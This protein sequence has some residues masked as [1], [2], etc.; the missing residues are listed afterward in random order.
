MTQTTI[1]LQLHRWAQ[2]DQSEI[3]CPVFM[4]D[5]S[6]LPEKLD[7]ISVVLAT[8]DETRAGELIARGAERVLLGD[9]VL[10]D[11]DVYRRLALLHGPER[12][13]VWVP[14][15]RMSVSWQLDFHSNEDFRCVTPSLAKPT[16]E[17]IDG[18]GQGTGTDAV[19]WLDQMLSQ[20]VAMALLAVDHSD[21]HDLNLCAELV[22][23][24]A[25]QVYLSPLD[26]PQ[27]D[28]VPWVMFGQA[29]HLVL[30]AT[31]DEQAL[32]A[33]ITPENEIQNAFA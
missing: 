23:C 13:G 31:Y 29:Q 17:I 6:D 15:R 8:G 26:S 30:P 1:N 12:F 3:D 5:C 33:I 24:Y 25:D 9:A 18:D 19:W 10:R 20:G 22:E 27:A 2:S 16:W 21:D 32:L 4:H 11:S 14:V 28:L 7:H